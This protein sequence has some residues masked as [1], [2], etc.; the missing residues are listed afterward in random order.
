MQKYAIEIFYSD[1]DEGFLSGVSE[2]VEAKT[3]YGT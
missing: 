2:F 1:E 3:F